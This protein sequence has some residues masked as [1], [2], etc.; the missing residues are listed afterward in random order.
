MKETIPLSRLL[1]YLVC[2]GFI[3]LFCV[4][5]FFSKNNSELN[6][7]VERMQAVQDLTELNEQ[8]QAINVA[9]QNAF[10]ESDHFYVD[11]HLEKLDF[12]LSEIESIKKVMSHETYIPS[13]RLQRRLEFLTNNN[14]LSFTEGLVESYTFFQDTIETLNYPIEVN[15]EDIKK[16]LTYIE[17]VPMTPYK[18]PE[19]RPQMIITDFKLDKQKV[20]EGYEVYQLKLK[21]LKREFL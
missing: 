8:K 6:H 13:D 3:P 2:L 1:I 15:Q 16:I 11:K 20:S 4:L 17:G 5:L 7:L 9:V 14:R 12:L 19:L 10:H 18:V 21:F